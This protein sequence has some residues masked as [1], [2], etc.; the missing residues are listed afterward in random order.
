MV[1]S[2]QTNVRPDALRAAALVTVEGI[3]RRRAQ[4]QPEIDA[5]MLQFEQSRPPATRTPPQGTKR[6]SQP[7]DE[8]SSAPPPAGSEPSEDLPTDL[9]P[10]PEQDQGKPPIPSAQKGSS[11]AA[12]RGRT[13]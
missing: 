9:V 13:G 10:Q 6:P 12:V 7:A 4:R 3:R 11:A 8:P 5:I 1:R 2:T